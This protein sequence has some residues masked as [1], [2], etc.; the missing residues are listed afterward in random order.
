MWHEMRR[1]RQ[2]LDRLTVMKILDRATSGVLALQGN[3]EY[4]YAVPISYV[5]DG[6]CLYFHSARTGH[7]LEAIRQNPRA[8]FCV[9]DQDEVI[10]ETYTTAFG[11]VI[12]F[13]T[14]EILEEEAEKRRGIELLGRKYAPDQAETHLQE[15]IRREWPALS[16][17]RMRIDHATGKEAIELTR[18]RQ[19]RQH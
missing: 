13:G 10:P 18:K 2:E 15:E 7:K 1:K 16:V 5:R 6:D 12:V 19:S 4:P 9:I 8:S 11:S 17:L 3:E 14:I